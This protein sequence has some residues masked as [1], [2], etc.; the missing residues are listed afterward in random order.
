MMHWISKSRPSPAMVV[1]LIALFVS[2]GGAGYAAAKIGSAQVKNNSLRGK[3]IRNSTI[4]GKDVR[5]SGL[6]GT[7]VKNGSLTGRDTQDGSLT[8]GDVQ[9]NGLTSG[10]V[11]NNGLTS[12]DIRNGSLTGNDV[13]D[14][15]LTGDDILESTL[16][17]VPS[18]VNADTATNAT[19]A[20]T[21]S[22]A[23]AL[24]GVAPGGYLRTGTRT[25]TVG[26]GAGLAYTDNAAL[27]T[28]NVPAGQYAIT[29]KTSLTNNDSTPDNTTCTL[30]QGG[31][32]I[33]TTPAF[34][35]GDTSMGADV[36]EVLPFPL[37]GIYS[38]AA[39]ALTINCENG[40]GDNTFSYAHITAVKV[41]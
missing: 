40:G 2:M 27:V 3:D 32:T 22:N 7:D 24:G 39:T 8:S 12:D 4:T 41:G 34:L 6:A 10:D 14:D 1:A 19:N 13:R 28:L 37:V 5:N 11:Q 35:G 15:S 26:S 17:K 16:G 33:D 30:R 25:F 23:Q 20:V 9:N 38:G 18:A 21:A 29:A 31:T 36:A